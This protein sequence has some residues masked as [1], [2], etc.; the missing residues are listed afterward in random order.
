MSNFNNGDLDDGI[1]AEIQ[2]QTSVQQSDNGTQPTSIVTPTHKPPFTPDTDTDT[3]TSPDANTNA[4]TNTN[5]NTNANANTNANTNANAKANTNQESNDDINKNPNQGTN[6]K[7]GSNS[8]SN[9]TTIGNGPSPKPTLTNNEKIG[10]S[11]DKKPSMNTT[12]IGIGSVAALLVVAVVIFIFLKKRKSNSKNIS[13]VNSEKEDS[14]YQIGSEFLKTDNNITLPFADTTSDSI[15]SDVISESAFY[16]N[17]NSAYLNNENTNTT[18][19]KRDTVIDISQNKTS[20]NNN[21]NEVSQYRIDLNFETPVLDLALPKPTFKSSL[22]NSWFP[23]DTHESDGV[24]NEALDNVKVRYVTNNVISSPEKVLASEEI[25]KI[26]SDV[27][28]KMGN[29]TKIKYEGIQGLETIGENVRLQTQTPVSKTSSNSSINNKEK[30][31]SDE[32]VRYSPQTN[33]TPKK[34]ILKKNS[35]KRTYNGGTPTRNTSVKKTTISQNTNTLTRNQNSLESMSINMSQSDEEINSLQTIN[36][37]NT[38][39]SVATTSSNVTGMRLPPAFTAFH[40]ALPTPPT[41][42][43]TK[44]FGPDGELLPGQTINEKLMVPDVLNDAMERHDIHRNQ[45]FPGSYCTIRR[46]VKNSKDIEDI[47]KKQGLE[48]DNSAHRRNQSQDFLHGSN[49]LEYYNP[50]PTSYNQEVNNKEN[51]Q[52]NMP[53]N[54]NIPAKPPRRS[55]VSGLHYSKTLPRNFN[56]SKKY[57]DDYSRRNLNQ[58]YNI[59]EEKAKLTNA[60]N[61]AMFNRVKRNSMEAE[62]LIQNANVSL[63]CFEED[64]LKNS[65]TGKDRLNDINSVISILRE[66]RRLLKQVGLETPK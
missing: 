47:T 9:P 45:N 34:S 1:V 52:Y 3:S 61:E 35:T 49:K 65:I 10:S 36:R 48:V 46:K 12:A 22:S 25:S 7:Y 32:I 16:K 50:K 38:V 30:I 64:L 17:R 58:P 13:R 56:S 57:N 26:D 51:Y 40:H 66:E 24:S 39:N 62:F 60:R 14:V 15:T 27:V 20:N 8:V 19:D 53:S 31:S 29:E 28:T 6:D 41:P 37:T 23:D 44:F 63:T 4:N 2:T 54:L 42:K 11:D 43:S 5:T 33:L 59:E 21:G 55:N 18:N